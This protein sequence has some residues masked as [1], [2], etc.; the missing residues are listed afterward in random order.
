MNKPL[1]KND[2]NNV[3][4][5][6]NAK[7]SYDPVNPLSNVTP[8]PPPPIGADKLSQFV[9]DNIIE[10]ISHASAKPVE[11]D[12]IQLHEIHPEKNNNFTEENPSRPATPTTMSSVSELDSDEL[13]EPIKVDPRNKP[14][15]QQTQVA[16]G[17]AGL[18]F[19]N[20]LAAMKDAS[21]SSQ[22][23]VSEQQ[24]AQEVQQPAQE[25]QS[26]T[27]TDS[28]AQGLATLMM[29][30]IMTGFNPSQV[31]DV[32]TKGSIYELFGEPI[33]Q[34]TFTYGIG[35][36]N[37]NRTNKFE[38]E[39]IRHYFLYKQPTQQPKIFRVDMGQ[40][41]FTNINDVFVGKLKTNKLIENYL[42]QKYV[43]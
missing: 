41:S 22:S 23:S 28:A 31:K 33:T 25:V 37:T 3:L 11:V 17:F 39:L 1:H 43:K 19:D 32:K 14:L 9:F 4:N 18:L 20:I 40:Q 38:P 30:S 5:R 6:A 21:V 42:T 29:N 13:S 34:E 26:P 12:D 7:F 10:G 2:A 8:P 36:I 16:D 35:I 24:P 27:S 15:P